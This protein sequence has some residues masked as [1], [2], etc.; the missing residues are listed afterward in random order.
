MDFRIFYSWQSD[1]PNA[2]NRGFIQ[3]AVERA[4]RNVARDDTVDVEPVVDRDTQG[5]TGSPAI[6]HAIFEKI[7]NAQAFV[8]DISIINRGTEGRKVPNPNVLLELGFAARALGW[9]RVVL[10]FNT[11]TGDPT[12]DLPFDLRPRRRTEYRAEPGEADRS[13]AKQTLIATLET[14]IRQ[15]IDLERTRPAEPA[16]PSVLDLAIQA[17]E[18]QI[19]GRTAKARRYLD[20]LIQEL[21]DIAPNWNDQSE[22]D[23]QLIVALDLTSP[24]VC[25]FA[26]LCQTIAQVDERQCLNELH[27]FF[28]RILTKYDLPPNFSGGYNDWQFDFWKFMGH[29]LLVTC[30]QH[31]LA[32][33]RWESLGDLLDRGFHSQRAME[34]RNDP[35]QSFIHFSAHLRLLENRKRRLGLNWIT[36]HGQTLVERHG[37]TGAVACVPLEGFTEAEIYLFCKGEVLSERGDGWANWIPWTSL[38]YRGIP[39]FISDSRRLSVADEVAASFGATSVEAMKSRLKERLPFL[40]QIWREAFTFDLPFELRQIDEI[41]S[42]P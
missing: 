7:G 38:Y 12:V 40:R 1:L 13:I 14:A 34:R 36:L 30:V 28:E 37:S 23:D 39:R 42:R 33:R 5:L 19:P 29:E 16:P 41:G 15:M 18:S 32:E 11:A 22:L 9:D 25:G 6:D 35:V 21:E 3:D 26:L 27:R 4:A 10:I 31:L 2:T 8:A 24:L 20:E 17:V